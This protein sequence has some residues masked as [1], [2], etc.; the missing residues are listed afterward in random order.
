MIKAT[1]EQL[2]ERIA[3]LSG[4]S[5]EEIKRKV[6][7]KR[8]KLSGLISEEGAAQVVAAELGISFER[9]KFKIADL[10]IGMKKVQVLG[11]VLEIY[12][13]RQYKRAEH[14]GE[15]ASFL[16]A[17]ENSNIR[18]V[19]WDTK[20]IDMLKNGAIKKDSVLEIRNGDVR[21]TTARELHLSSGAEIEI[22]DK[23]MEVVKC[24]E[25]LPL[26]KISE[27]K[28]NERINI[29]AAIVQIFQPTPFLVC[30]ECSLKISYEEDKAL[31]IRHGNII[32]KKRFLIGFVLDDGTDNIRAVAFN[33]NIAKLFNLGEE[34]EM[35]QDSG[36]WLGKKQE[37][38]GTELLFSGRTRKNV[39][40]D[41]N[42][43]IVDD[44]QEIS[45]D[46]LIKELGKE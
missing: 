34:I 30:P 33:E 35:L 23:E 40:F 43:F 46:E 17:D 26:K 21:G 41:R 38:L 19:L 42:E 27:L 6:E 9:Q 22:S 24:P 12:P 31:C 15:I 28:A 36:F 20:H 13:I 8:A 5:T 4:Q 16:L 44:L 18:S 25:M 14:E 32:P 39:L 7:A 2:V 11:K 10:L 1:Y 3:N 29:R 37:L 45:P